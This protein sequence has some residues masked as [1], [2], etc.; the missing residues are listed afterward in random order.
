M[1]IAASDRACIS[2][3]N[4]NRKIGGNYDAETLANISSDPSR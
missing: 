4:G 2:N 1:E 3:W